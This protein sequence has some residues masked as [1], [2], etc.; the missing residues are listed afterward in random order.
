MRFGFL[1]LRAVVSATTEHID[2]LD[3]EWYTLDSFQTNGDAGVVPDRMQKLE[4]EKHSVFA[5]MSA[6]LDRAIE[7]EFAIDTYAEMGNETDQTESFEDMVGLMRSLYT[8]VRFQDEER[9]VELM[10]QMPNVSEAG[11]RIAC[12]VVRDEMTSG[13]RNRIDLL[14]SEIDR[15]SN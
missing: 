4:N 3:S 6:V 14:D 5:Q 7:I 12:I 13:L 2:C 8:C 11:L 1:V 15:L 10:T 9:M